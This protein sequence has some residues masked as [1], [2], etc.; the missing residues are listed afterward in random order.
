MAGRRT[1]AKWCLARHGRPH[2]RCLRW[3]SDSEVELIFAQ[4]RDFGG[5]EHQRRASHGRV[6][7]RSGVAQLLVSMEL[8]NRVS[9]RR[10]SG[11]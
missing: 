2:V 5:L 7:L 4:V 9:A 11:R 8:P 3:F 10:A 6:A 1:R